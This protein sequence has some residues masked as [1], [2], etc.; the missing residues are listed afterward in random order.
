[1]TAARAML[2]FFMMLSFLLTD[3]SVPF[4]MVTRRLWPLVPLMKTCYLCQTLPATCPMGLPSACLQ[5]Y[6]ADISA[7]VLF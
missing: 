1:V 7:V 6:S 5:G 3:R 4:C 2:C